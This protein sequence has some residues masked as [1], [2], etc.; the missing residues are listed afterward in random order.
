MER[1]FEQNSIKGTPSQGTARRL[2][3][4][5]SVGEWH[6]MWWLDTLM[7]VIK[8][9]IFYSVESWFCLTASNHFGKRF[10]VNWLQV[11][12]LD[13]TALEMTC[14][15][16]SEI[17]TQ[18]EHNVKF[19]FTIP[20]CNVVRINEILI[21]GTTKTLNYNLQFCMW[22]IKYKEVIKCGN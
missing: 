9:V 11:F 13:C 16:G 7:K 12:V 10:C 5:R 2:H 8:S 21:F 4:Q 18:T 17:L 22:T 3:K 15:N 1:N 19:D 14:L 6:F 20:H